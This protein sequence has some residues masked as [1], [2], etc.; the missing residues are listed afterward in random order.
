M[1][2]FFIDGRAADSAYVFTRDDPQVVDRRE[3]VEDLWRPTRR[4]LDRNLRDDARNHFLERFWEMYLAATLLEKGFV[5]TKH[6][7]EGPEF[8]A[9]IGTERVWFEAVAPTPG[10]GPD[11]VRELAAGLVPQSVP[12]DQI[13]MRFTNAF[14]EKMK[15]YLVA[16]DRNIVAPADP[17]ILAINSSAIQWPESDSN[18]PYFVRAFLG[19][20]SQ[21]IAFD[22]KTHEVVGSSFQYRPKIQKSNG[23]EV[24]TGRLFEED[25]GF[26]SA[27]IHSAD[28]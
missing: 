3:F 24:S 23:A 28:G 19:V 11:Q 6:G 22:T 10:T 1:D 13:L 14:A 15:R 27:L 17:Y 8:S 2:T 4:Y 12:V 18:V 7:D 16:I 20:G 21:V 26:C 5:L 9:Q 25:A